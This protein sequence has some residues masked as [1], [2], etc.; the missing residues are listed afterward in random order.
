MVL[1]PR[2]W[3]YLEEGG[4]KTAGRSCVSCA[5]ATRR[6]LCTYTLRQNILVIAGG[7]IKLINFGQTI[8]F[9]VRQKLNKFE[10]TLQY[11]TPEVIQWKEYEGPHSGCLESGCPSVFHAHKEMPIYGKH[12]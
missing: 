6:A 5:T 7:N 4:L 1:H 2:V 8:R 11:F 10:G 9:M 3:W 12:H